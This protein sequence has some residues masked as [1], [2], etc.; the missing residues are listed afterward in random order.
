MK[1]KK[2]PNF[3]V[4]HRFI[5]AVVASL[6]AFIFASAGLVF[7][8]PETSRPDDAHI[9]VV[10]QDGVE[11]TVVTRLDTVG[12]LIDKLQ[13]KISN[14]DLLEPSREAVINSDNFKIQIRTA[15]PT[16]IIADGVTKSLLSPYEDSRLAVEKSG[17]TLDQED[18]VVEEFSG[19]ITESEILGRKLVVKRAVSVNVVLYG[20]PISRK[21]QSKD[22]S[23]VLKDMNITPSASDSIS[24]GLN[25]EVKS[26]MSIF[27]TKEG[28]EVLAVEEVIAHTVTVQEDAASNIGYK[29]VI[30]AGQDGKKLVFYEVNKSTGAKTRILETVVARPTQEILVKGT[31]S[32]FA[33]FNEDGIPARVFCGSPKQ[34]NWKN[35]NITNAAYGRELA[36]ERGWTGSEFD[37]LLELFA[38]ESS[39]NERAGNP[40]SG[41][42]G[43]PQAWPANKMASFG[44]DYET[45]PITQLRWGLNYIAAR[46]GT[47]SEALA[48]HYRKNYY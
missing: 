28:S 44:E 18:V 4:R 30:Q 42:Y 11:R 32:V 26:G 6:L 24:P 37:A 20:A 23:G 12:E 25:T 36:K 1:K 14:F 5:L 41:A 38:C 33:N 2:K 8:N 31:K 46:Y 15:E 39:W 13:I 48:F 40:Y 7:A 34:G 22:V 3:I 10:F 16:T 9:V 21:T 29:K 27:V 43:I 35:I 17:I 19:S 47:P 45:N